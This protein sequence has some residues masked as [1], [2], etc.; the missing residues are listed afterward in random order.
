MAQPLHASFEQESSPRNRQEIWGKQK[1]QVFDVSS[2]QRRDSSGSELA[3]SG[4][5][6]LDLDDLECFEVVDTQ[7][8]DL[9]VTFKNAI[10]LHPSNPAFPPKS[11]HTVITGG[12]KSGWLE[13]TFARPVRSVSSCVTGSRRT[14]L[15]G[16]DDTNQLVSQDETSG[17]NLATYQSEQTTHPPNAEL[18][19]SG[20]ICRIKFSSFD[21]QLT[22]GALS[23]Q[24]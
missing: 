7:Y 13:A 24:P 18:V 15:M 19:V 8:E 10:A 4:F 12:P 5:V 6:H 11:G 17:A 20:N 1:P 16:F 3:P 23:F 22:V 21:G 14:V 9:G 2:F